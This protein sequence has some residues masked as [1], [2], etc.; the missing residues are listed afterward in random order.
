VK[1]VALPGGQQGFA[2]LAALLIAAI[3]LLATATLVAAALSST[4]ISADD[5]ASARA[6]D[7]ADA[8]VADALERLRW[9]WLRLDPSSWPAA[10]ALTEFGGGSYSVA[11]E[12]L[13][14]DDLRPRLDPSSPV[15]AG[16]PGV[17]ACRV[18]L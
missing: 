15:S 3:A 7:V 5:A 18:A 9:G 10:I 14:G 1:R 11:L 16:D 13:S 17:I 12:A 2:L 4:A 8:G 6:A